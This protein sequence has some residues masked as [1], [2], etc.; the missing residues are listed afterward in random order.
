MSVNIGKRIVADTPNNRMFYAVDSALDL[1]LYTVKICSNKNIFTEEYQ[2]IVQQ[3]VDIALTI[4]RSAWT[5]NNIR[6]NGNAGRWE[7]RESY[8][9]RSIVECDN[10][11]AM[12]GLAKFLF[13]LKSAKEK[14][15]S[16]ST[17]KTRLLLEKWKESDTKRYGA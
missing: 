12:I 10:L 1:A 17:L 2:N 13:H 3:I 9:D 8:E 7:I 6:V 15:W 11:L 4:Y 16:E 5:A 14:Y